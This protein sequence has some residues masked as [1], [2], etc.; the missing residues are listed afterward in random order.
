MAFKVPADITKAAVAAGCTKCNMTWQKLLV[1][2][3]LAGAYIAFGALLSEIVAGGLSNGSITGPGG[4]VWKI[5]LPAG[6]VKFAAGAVFPVGLILVVIAGSELFTGNCMFAPISVLN[7]EAS[8]RGLAKNWSL[9]Y[10]GNLVGSV[11]VAYFLAYQSGLFD[12]LPWAGWA[13]TVANNKCGLDFGTAFLRGIGCNWLVCLA[14]WLAISSEDVI[15]KIFSCWFP[16]M[17]FVTIG[18]EHSVANM[19]FIP[20]GIF[21]ANDPAIAAQ[22]S[23]AGVATANLM[24]GTGW[25]N[26]FITNLVPVTLGNIAGAALFVSLLYWYVYLRGPLCKT[27]PDKRGKQ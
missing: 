22:L 15:S 17:A 20:L 12:G 5:A 7:G 27:A 13:A 23:G 18:F 8:L 24:G 6:L 21:A 10:V 26:F 16:I 25:Y 2:G 14:V 19:F 1:L 3:F 9:V 11:F 4:E